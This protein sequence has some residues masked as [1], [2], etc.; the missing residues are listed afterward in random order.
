MTTED[1]FQRAPAAAPRAWQ[2]LLVFADWLAQRDDPRADGYR[3]LGLRRFA[4]TFFSKC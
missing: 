2:T 3:A 1:D 4:P